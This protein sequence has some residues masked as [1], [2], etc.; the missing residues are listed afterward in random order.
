M[1]SN[2]S[3]HT[4]GPSPARFGLLMCA[5]FLVVVSS[6]SAAQ[7]Q[8]PQSI[9]DTAEQFVRQSLAGR[10]DITI[11][12]RGV[13]DRVKLPE[14][15]RPLDAYAERPLRNGRGSVSVASSRHSSG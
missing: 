8:S 3:A 14:C 11:D 15:S 10:S 5:G 13:D 9:R 4:N 1:P 2:N 7:W 12:V 6:A